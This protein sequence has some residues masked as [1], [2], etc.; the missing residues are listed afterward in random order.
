[1]SG[2]EWEDE[3]RLAEARARVTQPQPADPADVNRTYRIVEVARCVLEDEC[4]Q[5]IAALFE[6]PIM[7]SLIGSDDI[8]ECTNAFIFRLAS[9]CGALV[10]QL[11]RSEHKKY[12]STLFLLLVEPGLAGEIARDY[13]E[14]PCMLDSFTKAF[15]DVNGL[16]DPVARLRLICIALAARVDMANVEALHAS[17]R[18]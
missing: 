7:W 8:T 1:M 6:Q 4:L 14:T 17:I 5:T 10:E 2:S 13:A 18:R 16:A 9:R 12:P 15:L 3:Q 11:Q